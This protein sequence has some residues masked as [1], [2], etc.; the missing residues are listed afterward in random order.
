MRESSK[1]LL[2]YDLQKNHAS[3]SRVVILSSK[4][5]SLH[6]TLL[7]YMAMYYIGKIL[8]R[9]KELGEIYVIFTKHKIRNCINNKT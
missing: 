9:K 5:P 7:L 8:S 1:K 4:I 2:D 6:K 3:Y